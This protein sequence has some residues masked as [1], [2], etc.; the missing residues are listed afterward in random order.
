MKKK[1]TPSLSALKKKAWSLC[2]RY[3]RLREADEGGFVHCYTCGF[4]MHA[5]QEAQAGHA[6][7]GRH[8]AVLLDDS[9]CRPQCYSC[10]CLKHG[11]HHI[12]ATKLAQENGM[13]WWQSKLSGAKAVVKYT[14]SD[15]EALIETYKAKL[16]ELAQTT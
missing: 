3:V 13:E 12:F 1:K 9:I 15:L 11:M 16:D 7:P 2:S 5:I 4:P 6:I 8:N 10:N 14:R